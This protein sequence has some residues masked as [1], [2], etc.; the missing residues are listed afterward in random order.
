[1]QANQPTLSSLYEPKARKGFGLRASVVVIFVFS[2]V[3]ILLIVTLGYVLLSQDLKSIY[4]ALDVTNKRELLELIGV[5]IVGTLL[6]I[7]AT[8]SYQRAAALENS[9]LQQAQSNNNT[10]LGQRQQRLVSAIEHLGSDSETIRL[11][12]AYELFQLAVD[13][14]ELR[15]EIFEILCAQIRIK[16]TTKKY[17]KMHGDGP[18]EEIQSLLTLLF[19][20]GK[21]I[22]R[23]CEANLSRCWLPWADLS[24]AELPGATLSNANLEYALLWQVNLQHA[25]CSNANFHH[26][27]LNDAQLMGALC[28]FANFRN[29]SMS[30]EMHEADFSDANFDGTNLKHAK[31][32]VADLTRVS[33]KGTNLE[34][35]NLIGAVLSDAELQGSFVKNLQLQGAQ[36]SNCDLRGVISEGLWMPFDWAES[37]RMRCDSESELSSVIFQGGIT[38]ETIRHELACLSKENRDSLMRRLKEEFGKPAIHQPLDSTRGFTIGS[39]SKAELEEWMDTTSMEQ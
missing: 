17:K 28:Y 18:S 2:A 8:V 9:V 32:M 36:S 12:G 29:A 27:Y 7:Q 10:E 3:F 38:L 13:T 33:M 20:K 1:M 11:G 30:A 6:T 24:H 19:S 14:N 39:Y 23:G 37:L 26:A 21:D 25:D 22:F 34:S 16:T 5:A 4:E 31:M 35:A 15:A